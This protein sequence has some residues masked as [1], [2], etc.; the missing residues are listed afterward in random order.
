MQ[1]NSTHLILGASG[2]IGTV[3][4]TELRKKY[5]ASAVI[6]SDIKI[7]KKES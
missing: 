3:L 4:T 7:P 1:Q 5:G 2:Q 6:A